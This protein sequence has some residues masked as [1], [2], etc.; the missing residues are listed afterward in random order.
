MIPLALTRTSELKNLA[1]RVLTMLSPEGARKASKS[2]HPEAPDSVIDMAQVRANVEDVG[3]DVNAPTF[4]SA[5]P[6]RLPPDVAIQ[7]WDELLSAVEMR[8]RLTA[9]ALPCSVPGLQS[10]DTLGGAQADVLECVAALDQLHTTLMNE[11]G[12]RR[13]LELEVFDAQ[14][15]L[16][17]ARVELA[18][19]QAVERRA[20]HMASHDGLTSLPNRSF[21]RERLDQA[22]VRAEPERRPLAV[23]YFDLD[24]FKKINDDHGHEAGDELLRIVA[25]RLAG[26]VRAEDMVGRL[27]GDEFACLLTDVPNREQLSHLAC[28]LYDTVSTPF[29]LGKLSLT[30]RPSIGIAMCPSDGATSDDLL[31]NA[32]A[33]MYRAKRHQIG[34]AFFEEHAGVW[35][36]ESE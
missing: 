7:D 16:A 19:T 33:A 5:W 36:Q 24:G 18:G 15:A 2:P 34:Y 20:R 14:T 10:H 30:V 4:A 8:L 22:L 12:R 9:D 1:Q 31:R 3:G 27:G 17:Q 23:L 26:A 21:F 13:Q 11:L 25:A 6:P 32:D 35:A 28:K 29:Q